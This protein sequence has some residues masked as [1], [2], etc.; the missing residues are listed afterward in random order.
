MMNLDELER[1][2]LKCQPLPDGLTQPRQLLYL[3][4]RALYREYRNKVIDKFQAHA[5]KVKFLKEYET[6]ELN[7]RIYA[8]TAQMRNRLSTYCTEIEKSGCPK[9]QLAVKIFDGKAKGIMPGP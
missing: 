1:L 6:A 7:Y 3:Q 8:E 4:F 9:C 5:E 2:A